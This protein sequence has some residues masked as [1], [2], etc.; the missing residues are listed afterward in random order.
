M[1]AQSQPRNP[2]SDDLKSGPLDAKPPTR[3]DPPTPSAT[4]Q[5]HPQ[6]YANP[7]DVERG[8]QAEAPHEIPRQG[9]RDI[10]LRVKN[11]LNEDNLSI[12]AAGVAFFVWLG[13]MPMMAA[14]ISIYGL[15]ADPTDVERQLSLLSGILPAEVR[16][17]IGEQ[18]HWIAS[19]EKAA[20]WGAAIGLVLA[21]WSGSKAM[22]SV[23][24][25]LNITYEEKEQRGYI[26]LTLVSLG[27]TFG[28]VLLGVISIGIVVLLPTLLKF[29]GLDD[30]QRL[31]VNL[32]RWPALALISLGAL[33]V[34]YRYGP[35]RNSPQWRWVT[36]GSGIATV[37]WLVASAL[38]SYYASHWGNYN[39]TYGSLGAI[40]LLLLWLYI[41]A[42]V[43][44]LGSE[45]NSEMEHQ[46]AKDT[47]KGEPKP[48]GQRGAYVADS[49]GKSP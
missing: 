10:A 11:E 40:T 18:M 22:S 25:A 38:F 7:Q 28:A 46:T 15:W 29:V 9:W 44:L 37:L 35:Y 49:V 27:L 19:Q 3:S 36:W 8:R 5:H 20:G 21:L 43:V 6:G 12:I 31:L 47:T 2:D 16:K 14:L 26:R 48:L 13:L 24:T 41:S 33:A 45:I 4:P 30:Q 34:L 23:I 32:L 42:Y 17:L 39:K 1:S